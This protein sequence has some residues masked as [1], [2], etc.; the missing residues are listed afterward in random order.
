[1]AFVDP[2]IELSASCPQNSAYLH[3]VEEE[4]YVGSSDVLGIPSVYRSIYSQ[5]RA[6][7]VDSD[8]VIP[9]WQRTPAWLGNGLSEEPRRLESSADK[10]SMLP[11]Y[12][13]LS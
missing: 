3:A 5:K 4:R 6:L 1:M 12:F 9:H 10:L 11:L 8:R 2:L 7:V 13:T